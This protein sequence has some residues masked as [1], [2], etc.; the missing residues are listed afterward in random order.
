MAASSE[1][2]K[3]HGASEEESMQA[4]EASRETRWEKP[5]FLRELFLGR[6]RLDLVHPFPR[7]KGL[8]DPEFIAYFEKMKKFLQE[9][10]DSDAIDRDRKIPPENLK[11]LAEM[12]AF[13]FKIPKEYG[14]KGFTVSQYSQLMK[15]VTSKDGNL[16]A[17][18]SAHQS[19]GVPQPLML[20]GSEEQ[21]KK[22]LP[23]IAKGA[24]TAFAL[25][26]PDVGS[27]PARVSTSVEESE[28]G[29]AYIMNGEKLWT[30][31]VTIADLVV[32]MAR[33]KED[34]KMSAF[35]VETAWE[36]VEV[37]YRCSFMGL[38]ALENGMIRFKNVRIPKENLLWER[39]KGLKLALVTLNTGRLALPA[40]TVGGAKTSLEV[41]RKWANQRV[42]WG[43]PIGKH[44]AIAHKIADMAAATFA[45]E[46]VADLATSMAENDFD[47]RLEAAVAKMYNTEAGWNIVDDTIQ[48]R[49]GR[50]YETAASLQAR[51]EPPVDVERMMRDSRIN[52]IFEGSSEIMRLFIAREAVDKHLE[53]AGIMLD[54]KKGMGAKIA[55][56]PKIIGFYAI[57]YPSLWLGWGRW[58]RY[59]EFGRLAGHMRYV[60]RATRKL[61]RQVFHA[62]LIY[63]GK[64]Q[65]KQAFL[66]RLVD[67]GAE[68]FAMAATISRAT[69][70][71]KEGNKNAVD[72]A[73][74]FCRLSRRQVKDY[75]KALWSNDDES[76][77][78]LSR[79]VLD[80]QFLWLEEGGVGIGV[81]DLLE[82]KPLKHVHHNGKVM[83][84][85][86]ML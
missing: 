35:I 27:D 39:G 6:L 46:S 33:H 67:I 23:R 49:G 3:I 17:L 47:I 18:L 1:N 29:K 57:W 22:Y 37:I 9:E 34:G 44:E 28:D 65:K 77:Y 2:T 63:Q 66:F 25:T 5:S 21:K 32:V 68:L 60:N 42:Q 38:K 54:P 55:A 11:K 73:D 81:E 51:G 86:E 7:L 62:M 41:V 13:G 4:A 36:G 84:A 48:I 78:R 45:M 71:A 26:E 8:D 24:V 79:K 40:A 30:T 19:I 64:L 10:V 56:L 69:K 58:P 14:G 31:N 20:F 53:V 43:Q 50:G 61:A 76:K 74:A 15:L 16:T 12:G 52:L 85:V 75:F 59:S 82:R 72:L 83:E 70:L 80:N